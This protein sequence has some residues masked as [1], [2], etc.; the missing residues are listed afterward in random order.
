M[1]P[2][3]DGVELWVRLLS[4]LTPLVQPDIP[5]VVIGFIEK[6]E[7]VR[8]VTLTLIMVAVLL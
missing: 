7:G 2:S 3:S 1:Q 4:S 5:I 8:I 6:G